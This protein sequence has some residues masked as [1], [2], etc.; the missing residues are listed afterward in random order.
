MQQSDT[1]AL[2]HTYFGIPLTIKT[3]NGSLAASLHTPL[4]LD[5]NGAP[6]QN[7]ALVVLLHGLAGTRHEHNGIFMRLAAHLATLGFS[8]LRFDFR[9]CGESFGTTL[10]IYPSA[11]VADTF[12]VVDFVLKQC[13]PESDDPLFAHLRAT[14]AVAGLTGCHLLGFSLGGVVAALSAVEKPA[15]F[16]SLT[17]WQAPFDLTRELKRIFGPLNFD[18]IRA[19]GYMQAGL[20]KLGAELFTELTQLDMHGRLAGYTGDVLVL[21]G[22]RDDLVRLD[23]NHDEWLAA[24]SGAHRQDCIITGADHGFSHYRQEQDA[25]KRTSQFLIECQA[26]KSAAGRVPG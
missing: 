17:I 26:E 18:R 19:R 15:L 12:A 16:D 8:V 6:R 4:S 10:D 1:T 23:P 24:L 2:N 25:I 7:N 22:D 20:T 5:P 9:G 11:Q 3:G 21:S 13:R 14:D